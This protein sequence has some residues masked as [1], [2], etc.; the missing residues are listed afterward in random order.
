MSRSFKSH[1][2]FEVAVRH[3]SEEVQEVVKYACTSGI[4]G[5][6]QDAQMGVVSL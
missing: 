5:R 2:K 6:V 1:I 4:Q 3:L